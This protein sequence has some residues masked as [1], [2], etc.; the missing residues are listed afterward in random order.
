M[1][2]RRTV[3][4]SETDRTVTRSRKRSS[5]NIMRTRQCSVCRW[6]WK[7]IERTYNAKAHTERSTL[8]QMRGIKPSA[9]DEPRGSPETLT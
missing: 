6:K 1:L 2:T 7:T 5:H 8:P 4:R 9:P 3:T